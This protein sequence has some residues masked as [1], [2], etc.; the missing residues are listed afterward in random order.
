MLIDISRVVLTVWQ[1]YYRRSYGAT[2]GRTVLTQKLPISFVQLFKALDRSSGNNDR[3]RLS[4]QFL[5]SSHIHWHVGSS[6]HIA[7]R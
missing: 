3:N 1:N 7:C 4:L 2:P 5:S 6:G